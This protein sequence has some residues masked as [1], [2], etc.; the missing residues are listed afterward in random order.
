MI[1]AGIYLACLAHQLINNQ[2]YIDDC[3]CHLT[4]CHIYHR[5]K[6]MYAIEFSWT[7]YCPHTTQLPMQ[8]DHLHHEL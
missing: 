6:A 7:F 1:V 3:E 2:F 8:P 4:Q 5:Y